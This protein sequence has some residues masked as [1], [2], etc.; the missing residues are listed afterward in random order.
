MI[1]AGNWKRGEKLPSEPELCQ[2]FAI[3]RSTLRE[4]LKSLAFMGIVE[5]RHGD[6]TYVAEGPS[7]LLDRI[8]AQGLVTSENVND[9]CEARIALECELVSLCARRATEENL[10]TLEKLVTEMKQAAH[11]DGPQFLKL[12]LDFHLT[13]AAY[14][15]NQVLANLLRT[16]R[17][18]LQE[19][20]RQ[21]Q[22]LP[23][24]RELAC[25]HHAKILEALKQHHPHR[26]RSAM[27]SH[28]SAF[29]KRYKILIKATHSDYVFFRESSNSERS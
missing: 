3:G 24:S 15:K 5:M 20:I 16:I 21:S 4:A 18:L 11:Q 19:L 22:E 6:G 17:D 7:K 27:R 25:A 26:A 12:D 2:A 23:G 13:M 29:Q 8:F 28:L 9:L 14:S 1:S 10:R